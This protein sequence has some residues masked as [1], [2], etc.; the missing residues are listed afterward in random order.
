MNNDVDVLVYGGTAA[1]ISASLAAAR[2][3]RRTVLVERGDHLGGMVAS[4]LGLIDVL[5][6]HAVSGIA[7]E[8][9]NKVIDHYTDIGIRP[10]EMHRLTAS[11]NHR[12]IQASD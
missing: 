9:K 5:R 4:G 10:A 11:R 7:L 2:A 6:P 3:G 1:G 8:F 12:R